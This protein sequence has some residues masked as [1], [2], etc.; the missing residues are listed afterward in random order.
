MGMKT[1]NVF[2]A[3]QTE[4]AKP[5]EAMVTI[6]KSE[7]DSLVED[8]KWLQALEDAGVDNWPG[9]DYARDLHDA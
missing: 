4:E 5:T 7:Y 1:S 8:A 3:P 9:I 6:T 2:T